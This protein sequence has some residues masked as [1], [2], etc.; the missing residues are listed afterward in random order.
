[1]FPQIDSQNIAFCEHAIGYRFPSTSSDYDF[2][3]NQQ[4]AVVG[5]LKLEHSEITKF[6]SKYPFIKQDK[7]EAT[8]IGLSNLKI[9]NQAIPKG[10]F[11]T[12]GEK[13]EHINWVIYL[14]KESGR[15]WVHVG[16]QDWNG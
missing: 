13:N 15:V 8:Y 9:E 4:N 3:D 10:T 7:T 12:S 14:H 11:F 16:Y 5:H 2:Y 6:L 1:V